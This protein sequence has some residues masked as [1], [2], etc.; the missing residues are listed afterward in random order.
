M[1]ASLIQIDGVILRKQNKTNWPVI[2]SIQIRFGWQEQKCRRFCFP[3]KMIQMVCI[4]SMRG[5]ADSRAL[6]FG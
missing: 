4:P 2:E 1:G 3:V 6:L 5:Q